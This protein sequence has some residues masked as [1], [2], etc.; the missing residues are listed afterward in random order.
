MGMVGA[1]ATQ[2]PRKVF[3]V[4]STK[5][6]D[7]MIGVVAGAALLGLLLWGIIHMSQEVTSHSLLTGRILS[8]HFEPQPEEQLTIGKG[9]L[10]ERDI[11]GIYTMEVQTPDGKMYK[12][13]VEKPVYTSRQ[14]GDE[15]SFLP[16]PPKP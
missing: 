11:D 7:V 13:F 6:R 8:K 5:A 9:G 1:M 3:V 16:P 10:D 12:V 15:L 14:P 2:R 4:K